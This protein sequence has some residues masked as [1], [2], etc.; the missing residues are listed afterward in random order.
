MDKLTVLFALTCA[1]LAVA[2]S[3]KA[4]QNTQMAIDAPTPSGAL[5]HSHDCKVPPGAHGRSKRAATCGVQTTLTAVQAQESVLVHNNFRAKETSSNMKSMV[6]SDEM[7]AVAQSW[8]NTCKWEHGNLYDCSGNR[9][10]QNLFVE[11]SIG[12][13]PAKNMTRTIEAWSGEKKD[14]TYS[15]NQCASGKMCGHYTQV[16]WANS[17]EVG[18]AAAQCPKMVVSGQ[19]WTNALF[20]VCDYRS[21]G[22][23]V[24]EPIY[25]SGTSCLNCDSE[26]TGAGYKCVNKLC[27]KCSPSTDSTCKCGTPA[28]PCQNGG[29]WSTTTCSCVCPKKFYG[30][31]C[32]FTCTCDDLEPQ[33][34]ADWSDFCQDADY[35]E[36]MQENCKKT[37]QYTCILPP[38]CS[39]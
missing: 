38:S 25:K 26:G 24:G 2:V 13:Y 29:S 20:I 18:C 34:C 17:V 16:V 23:V 21:P 6:W 31:K 1:L 39:A 11:A 28:S 5:A 36:Y 33:D 37:C 10:G 7:A 22:N 30:S 8:A 27:S 15:T 12:G 32:E 3:G 19:T 14:Y 35:A 4:T 9:V